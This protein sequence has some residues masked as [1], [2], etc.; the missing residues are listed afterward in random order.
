MTRTVHIPFYCDHKDKMA[1]SFL[2]IATIRVGF[3]TYPIY[4][5]WMGG[6][7][8]AK[9]KLMEIC[10]QCNFQLEE[11]LQGTNITLM[12]HLCKIS[13]EDFILAD[14]DLV[15]FDSVE[16]WNSHEFLS[17]ELIPK[18]VC[19]VA[20]ALTQP[21]LHTALLFV[22]KPQDMMHKIKTLYRPLLPQF[23]PYNPFVPT[24][25]YHEGK[26][27]FYDGCALLFHQLRGE[28]FPPS[29]LD[30][31]EHMY[32]GPY[33]DTIP[34]HKEFLSQVTFDP[35]KA[36]GFRATIMDKYYENLAP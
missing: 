27:I 7:E 1:I 15:F 24:V 9:L 36:K 4:V 2:F 18:F 28:A 16:G 21:R 17:G 20:F 13:Q 10:A 19:P 23:C 5:H 29:M 11:D 25:V 35:T 31:Y 12:E 14:S 3:P 32:A 22:H 8:K 33:I 30:K 6:V 34:R 26:P